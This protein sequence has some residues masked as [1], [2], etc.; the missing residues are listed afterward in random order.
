MS[1]LLAGV[2]SRETAL[3]GIIR[4]TILPAKWIPRLFPPFT[5]ARFARASSRFTVV[6]RL[7]RAIDYEP[8]SRVETYDNY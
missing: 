8:I 1:L 6:S 2:E 7:T 5:R 4:A 3:S